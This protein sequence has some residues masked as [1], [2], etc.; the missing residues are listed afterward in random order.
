MGWDIQNFGDSPCNPEATERGHLRW[1]LGGYVWAVGTWALCH[2]GGVL[3]P[4]YPPQASR[5]FLYRGTTWLLN[6]SGLEL[7]GSECG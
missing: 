1:E 3:P 6:P 7:R 2:R 5:G 4:G